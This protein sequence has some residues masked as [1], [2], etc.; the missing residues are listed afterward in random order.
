MKCEINYNKDVFSL[1]GRI[2][3]LLVIKKFR[4]RN[5]D[6]LFIINHTY[7]QEW[8]N[9]IKLKIIS[10]SL[11]LINLSQKP[12]T[13]LSARN[14]KIGTQFEACTLFCFG[15]MPLLRSILSFSK[16]QPIGLFRSMYCIAKYW[17]L[18]NLN[19]MAVVN[20]NQL[21]CQLLKNV[22]NS[23]FRRGCIKAQYNYVR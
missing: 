10:A 6:N 21:Y 16:N 1:P 15:G 2:G 17:Q 20:L 5:K 22:S 14:N 4:I 8:F 23:P 7:F 12:L 13:T 3:I 19:P 11:L 18:S 9:G